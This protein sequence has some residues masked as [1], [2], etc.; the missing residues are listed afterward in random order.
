M[1]KRCSFALLTGARMTKIL[2]MIRDKIDFARNIAIVTGD[3]AKSGRAPPLPLNQKAID[4]LR[5]REVKRVSQYVF[6]RGKG[7]LISEIDNEAFR[8]ALLK[9]GIDDFRFHDLWHTWARWH[10]QSGTPLLV[11]K[12]MGGW[13]TIEMVQKYAH[14][15]AK[16]LLTYANQVKF[17]SNSFLDTSKMTAENEN[18]EVNTGNKKAVSY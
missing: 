17:S 16:H 8:R 11:L 9:A 7:K 13:E 10:V 15:N 18:M 3:I 5:Q 14:L 6:H 2:T 4:L 12:E 1:V